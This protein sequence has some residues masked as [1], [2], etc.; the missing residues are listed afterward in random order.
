MNL[1]Q[2]I[3]H[4]AGRFVK[5]DGAADVE[6]AMQRVFGASQIAETD[7]DLAK[8]RE[9]DGQPVARP[10]RFVQRHAALRQRERLL[11]AVLEQHHDR[12][13]PADRR[14]DVVSL[15]RGCQ[16]LCVT[17]RRHRFV[18]PAELRQRDAR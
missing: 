8:R 12:L 10:V 18:V 17:Q 15:N 16:P 6:G 5:L 3:E 2:R 13:V 11:V 9:R 1:R 4:R 7:A 14:H